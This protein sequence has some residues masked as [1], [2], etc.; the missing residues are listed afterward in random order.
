MLS[1]IFNYEQSEWLLT[2]IS[3]SE[4][5]GNTT[6]KNEL[7]WS[8]KPKLA[9]LDLANFAT[10]QTGE[11]KDAD[12][13]TNLRQEKNAT[14]KILEKINSG[15]R[16]QILDNSSDWWRIKNKEKTGYIHKSKI[17]I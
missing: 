16:I 6:E 5:S 17:S 13:Y 7:K 14:S 11:I 3:T 12:G 10:Y 15:T 4:K 1:F 2:R 8:K 9:T